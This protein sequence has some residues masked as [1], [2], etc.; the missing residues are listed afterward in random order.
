MKK[1]KQFGKF[2]KSAKKEIKKYKNQLSMDQKRRNEL[3]DR[4]LAKEKKGKIFVQGTNY[5]F[6]HFNFCIIGVIVLCV[7]NKREQA[8]SFNQ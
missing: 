1:N 5:F 7:F 3:R 8:R 2:L 4:L 6:G